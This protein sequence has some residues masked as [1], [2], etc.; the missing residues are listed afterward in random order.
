MSIANCHRM[1]VDDSPAAMDNVRAGTLQQVVINSIETGDLLFL[2]VPQSSPVKLWFL[3]FPAEA[4][5]IVKA[6]AE[7]RRINV[8]LLGDA[9]HVDTGATHVLVFRDG[10]AGTETCCHSGST[11]PAGAGADHKKVVVECAHSLT[12]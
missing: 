6:L 1:W 9:A 3:A 11:H 12:A 2:V 8:E 10:Y 4:H 5:S 7:L